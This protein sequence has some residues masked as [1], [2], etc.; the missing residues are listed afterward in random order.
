MKQASYIRRV[1]LMKGSDFTNRGFVDTQSQKGGEKGIQRDGE[2]DYAQGVLT[3]LFKDELNRHE[4]QDDRE[5][6][7]N[8][9]VKN[10]L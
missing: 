2:I 7:A 3:Q 6:L 8:N 4:A 5:P 1:I 10:I 9:I